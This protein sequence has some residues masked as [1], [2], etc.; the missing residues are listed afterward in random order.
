MDNFCERLKAARIKKGLSQKN[1]SDYLGIIPNSYRKYEYGEREPDIEKLLK[2]SKYL[3]CSVYWLLGGVVSGENNEENGN[4]IMR[5]FENNM[6]YFIQIVKNLSPDKFETA[7]ETLKKI[8]ILVNDFIIQFR[9][10]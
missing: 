3:D 9:Y 8:E 7:I 10:D 5:Y 1:V 2:L 6:S 4:E